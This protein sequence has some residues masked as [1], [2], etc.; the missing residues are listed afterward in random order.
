MHSRNILKVFYPTGA[1]HG[2]TARCAVARHGPSREL[3]PCPKEL[4][5]LSCMHQL[6]PGREP[7]QTI[8]RGSRKRYMMCKHKKSLFMQDSPDNSSNPR[9]SHCFK[10][11][12]KWR[13]TLF[14]LAFRALEVLLV[15]LQ[16][17]QCFCEMF[18][19]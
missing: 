7:H 17:I 3:G 14:R 12:R 10:F 16:I 15:I 13:K 6:F 8:L 9:T 19:K 2:L 1:A 4:D 5:G 18:K 11:K